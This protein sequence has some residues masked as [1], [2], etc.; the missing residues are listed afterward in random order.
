MVVE[1]HRLELLTERVEACVKLRIE[2]QIQFLVRVAAV[3]D[4]FLCARVEHQ[5]SAM[6]RVGHCGSI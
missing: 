1:D 5:P 4:I 6:V 2:K 3:A